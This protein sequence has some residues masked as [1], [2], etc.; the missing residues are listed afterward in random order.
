MARSVPFL[1]EG[2]RS[3][4]DAS[5][6]RAEGREGWRSAWACAAGLQMA[7]SPRERVGTSV[8]GVPV[9]D[10]HP[11]PAPSIECLKSAYP[12]KPLKFYTTVV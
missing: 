3:G 5:E 11:A 4:G 12:W 6:G 7:A 8:L 9:P 2:R 10:P 1:S